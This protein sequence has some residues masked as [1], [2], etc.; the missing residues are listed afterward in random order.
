MSTTLLLAVALARAEDEAPASGEQVPPAEGDSAPSETP[1]P[2]DDVFGAPAP[3]APPTEPAPAGD[4]REDVFGAQARAGSPAPS[5]EQGLLGQLDAADDRLAIGGRLWL[6]T[7]VAVPEIDDLGADDVTTSSPN[8]M[9]LYVDGRPND[10]LRTYASARLYHDWSVL[11]GDTS[12]FGT[13]QS[14]SRVLLD[15]LWVKFD[16]GRKVYVTAGRQRVKWGAGR[17]WNPTDV[18]N[19]A[20]LD[21][22][23][24]FDERT[25]VSLIKVHV[26]L[27]AAGANLYAVADLEGANA[28][29]TPESA[30]VTRREGPGGA[31]RAEWAVGTGEFTATVGTRPG[32]PLRV[33]ADAN[34]G[35]GWFDLRV[36][37]A[38]RHGGDAHRWDGALDFGTFELPTKVDRSDEWIP[39]VVAA[40]E[41]PIGYGD[42]DSVNLGVEGFWNDEGYEDASLYTWLLTQ[43]EFQPFYLGR[44]YL[45]GYV[46]L[47]GPGDWNDTNIISSVLANLSDQ[48]YTARADV[49]TTVLTYLQLNVYGQYSFGENGEFH[50]ALDIP[51]IP[52]V[53]DTPVSV[54]ATR[55]A[56][57]VGARVA[58]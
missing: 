7:N 4:A 13:A 49:S 26:P 11:T 58:F 33:G 40:V 41:V 2:R 9:D 1:D 25:G 45:S 48:T 10:R 20:R 43:G 17:F 44:Q 38:L 37:G 57:G 15:Q 18:L 24:F 30:D 53:L 16:L 36:E 12:Q 8:F 29:W 14:T 3:D 23:A 21:S 39:Q 42:G 55:F 31:L 54:P 50:Y 32:G 6:R 56:T 22:L 51:A 5:G 47:Q 28:A 35:F 27:E 46:F 52:G 34:V 19:R